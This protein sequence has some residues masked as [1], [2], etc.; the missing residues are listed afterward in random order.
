MV[1]FFGPH[2]LVFLSSIGKF[3]FLADSLL[4]TALA[5]AVT[6]LLVCGFFW[7]FCRAFS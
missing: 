7:A 2:G 6:V 4:S 5:F 3:C 1:F